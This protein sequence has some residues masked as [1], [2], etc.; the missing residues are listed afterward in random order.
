MEIILAFIVLIIVWCVAFVA[1]NKHM[2]KKN[3]KRNKL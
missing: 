2:I 3:I 1:G